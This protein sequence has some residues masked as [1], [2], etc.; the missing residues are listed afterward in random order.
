[1]FTIAKLNIIF[2]SNKLFRVKYANVEAVSTICSHFFIKQFNFRKL[3][4]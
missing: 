1:M 3:C 2:Q 4:Q